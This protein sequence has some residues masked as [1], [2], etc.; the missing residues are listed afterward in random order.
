LPTQYQKK[1]KNNTDYIN[2]THILD[3]LEAFNPYSKDYNIELVNTLHKGK[4]NAIEFRA[5]P[6]ISIVRY[7][8]HKNNTLILH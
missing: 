5:L 7:I 4:Y 3:K 1:I 8:Y 6:L 2:L